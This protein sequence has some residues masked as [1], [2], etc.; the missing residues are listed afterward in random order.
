MSRRA[1]RHRCG[2]AAGPV[3]P[4][5]PTPAPDPSAAFVEQ[6]RLAGEQIGTATAALLAS[7]VSA[8]AAMAGTIASLAALVRVVRPDV[9]AAQVNVLSKLIE[10]SRS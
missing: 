7:G 8:E 6:S 5:S 4:S 1:G 10:S 9:A 3:R 2:R